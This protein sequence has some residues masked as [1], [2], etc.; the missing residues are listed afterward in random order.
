MSDQITRIRSGNGKTAV[1][2]CDQGHRGCKATLEQPTVIHKTPLH[3]RAV[4]VALPGVGGG[5]VPVKAVRESLRS[6]CVRSMQAFG[7]CRYGEVAGGINVAFVIATGAH[8]LLAG[9]WNLEEDV[10]G[11]G[12]RCRWSATADA[13]RQA[14]LQD[15][16]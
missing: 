15:W 5:G 8:D 11:G 7:L 10:S 6:G 4:Q 3:K 13:R 9:R 2:A 12:G 16:C 1:S 14:G